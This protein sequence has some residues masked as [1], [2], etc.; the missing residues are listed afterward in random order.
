MPSVLSRWYLNLAYWLIF[1]YIEKI[2]LNF[3]SIKH[4]NLKFLPLLIS[5]LL[6]I[7]PFLYGIFDDT[8]LFHFAMKSEFCLLVQNFG[9]YNYLVVTYSFIIGDIH[10][11][12]WL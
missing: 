8:I 10:F 5:T 9:W 12:T 3:R 11:L 6:N 1:A 4:C 2:L 7:V